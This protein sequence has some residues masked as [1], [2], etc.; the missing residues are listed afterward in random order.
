MV[1]VRLMNS[2]RLVVLESE[3]GWFMADGILSI[4]AGRVKTHTVTLAVYRTSEPAN[5]A[6]AF[7]AAKN[8]SASIAAAHPIPAAVMA[9]R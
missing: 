5:N 3:I 8:R 7:S 9:C 1:P 4:H 6:Y 2:R